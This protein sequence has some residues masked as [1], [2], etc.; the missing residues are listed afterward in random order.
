MLLKAHIHFFRIVLF[1]KPAFEVLYWYGDTHLEQLNLKMG[2]DQA[3]HIICRSLTFSEHRML[4]GTLS[5]GR[6]RP[7]DGNR[8]RDVTAHVQNVVT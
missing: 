8:K 1:R 3:R 5:N 2:D 7:D 4:I 6:R